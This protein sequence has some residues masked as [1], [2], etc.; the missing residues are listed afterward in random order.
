[1]WTAP[2]VASPVCSAGARVLAPPKRA[3]S[4]VRS[5]LALRPSWV[6][7]YPRA[8]PAGH[9]ALLLSRCWGGWREGSPATAETGPADPPVSAPRQPTVPVDCADRRAVG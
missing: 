3:I 4:L 6:L 2:E 9:R 7:R 5:L 1:M 8:V